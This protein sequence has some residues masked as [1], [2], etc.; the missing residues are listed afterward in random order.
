MQIFLKYV[1]PKA[2]LLFLFFAL[3]IVTGCGGGGSNEDSVA[4]GTLLPDPDEE[5][6]QLAFTL[7]GSV[8]DSGRLGNMT[9]VISDDLGKALET[10][11][12]DSH[13]RY[14]IEL[15]QKVR[16][17][18]ELRVLEKETLMAIVPEWTHAE[19]TQHVNPI[20]SMVSQ[21]YRD[22]L[23]NPPI[24]TTSRGNESTPLLQQV[25]F[26]IMK[27]VLGAGMSYDLFNT[28]PQFIAFGEKDAIPSLAGTLLETLGEQST[29]ENTTIEDLLQTQRSNSENNSPFLED[30]FFQ[31]GFSANLISDGNSLESV[32]RKLDELT[33]TD[34]KAHIEVSAQV[35]ELI[36]EHEDAQEMEPEDIDQL[37]NASGFATKEAY[38]TIKKW[39]E[40]LYEF[41]FNV[42]PNINLA[43]FESLLRNVDRLATPAMIPMV[44]NIKQEL[45]D[46]VARFTA[47]VNTARQTGYTLANLKITETLTASTLETAQSFVT[48]T[49]EDTQT[50]LINQFKGITDPDGLQAAIDGL[51]ATVR[52]NTDSVASTMVAQVPAEDQNQGISNSQI[53][54]LIVIQPFTSFADP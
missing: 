51:N 11:T 7:S 10:T 23:D 14:S 8:A 26:E 5:E 25:A 3:T 30:R 31:I 39:K 41:G 50:L 28:D 9:V 33:D 36:K 47:L 2:I 19:M 6:E 37:L 4:A 53:A 44:P 35:M 48:Q 15:P 54:D 42:S 45:T 29:W 49:V 27:T 34:A 18:L 17:P 16:F 46:G 43:E 24:E 32:E 52:D 13:G 22:I 12:T 20:T 40:V 21:S 38:R 1:S